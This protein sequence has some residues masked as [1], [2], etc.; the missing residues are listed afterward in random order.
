MPDKALIPKRIRIIFIV[1]LKF[2]L[3]LNNTRIPSPALD[4]SPATAA[5]KVIE[6]FIN[7]VAKAIDTAQLGINP[8]IEVTTGSKN[9]TVPK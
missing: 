8:T 7:N 5:P 6:P 2:S 3:C 1:S 9:F 4:K